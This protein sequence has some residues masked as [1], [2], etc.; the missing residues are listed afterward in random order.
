[1]CL[2]ILV[3]FLLKPIGGENK[4]TKLM[5]FISYLLLLQL[6]SGFNSQRSMYS[7][8]NSTSSHGNFMITRILPDGQVQKTVKW[9]GICGKETIVSWGDI[10]VTLREI[11]AN[12]KKLQLIYEGDSLTDCVDDR[13]ID[14]DICYDSDDDDDSVWTGDIQEKFQIL[15][16]V[17]A[18]RE[19]KWIESHDNLHR[20]CHLI[21]SQTRNLALRQHL[22]H[23]IVER[24][25]QQMV[26]APGTKW[27][28]PHRTASS[29][30]ELGGLNSVDRC[31]RRH[32]HCYRAIPP[33][34]ER[35]NFWNYMPFTLSHCGCDQRQGENITKIIKRLR[36]HGRRKRRNRR[37]LFL[38]PGTQWCGRG[39]RATKYT[40]LGGFGKADAC[41]RR[42]DTACPFYIPAFETR[43]GLFNWGIST[44]MHCTCDERFRTCLK[45][46]RTSAANFIGRIFFNVVQTKCFILK[47]QKVC[48]KSSWWG[49]CEKYQY[50]KQAHL[51]NNISY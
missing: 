28:G 13:P 29:Y 3:M 25:L 22:K 9:N 33:F 12:Q 41:C 30:K 8:I 48:E 20:R 38:M 44:L 17:E 24:S 39:N 43:Y 10:N 26:I 6:V 36:R 32:D 45:M 27:C 35:Y 47:P 7:T 46:A 4:I 49:K 18:P 1:M 16:Q 14:Q 51:R 15:D 11:G 37:E 50:R 23:R 42:H 40:N 34:S 2:R 19:I 31:C 21:K 5:I